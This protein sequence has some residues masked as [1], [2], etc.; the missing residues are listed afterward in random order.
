MKALGFIDPALLG[1]FKPTYKL[2]ICFAFFIFV[3]FIYFHGL[4]A[5]LMYI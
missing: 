4:S 1:N 5:S 3:V 2:Y